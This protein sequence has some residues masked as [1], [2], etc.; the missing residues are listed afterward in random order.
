MMSTSAKDTFQVFVS[1]PYGR[2]EKAKCYWDRFYQYAILDLQRSLAGRGYHINFVRAKEEPSALILKKSV[3]ELIDSSDIC[4]AVITGLNPNVFWEIG[5]A[6]CRE[7]PIIFVVELTVNEPQYSPALVADALKAFYN[8]QI[9]DSDPPDKALVSQFQ[10]ESIVPLLDIAVKHARAA[11]TLVPIYRVLSDRASIELPQTIAGASH[12]IHLLTPDLTYFADVGRFS[13]SI[14][15][16]TQFAFDYPAEQNVMINIL[17]LNPDTEIA[18]YRARQL[19][20][21]CARYRNNSRAAAKFFYQRYRNNRDVDI[22][23]YDD[24]PLQW[25]LVVDERVIAGFLSRS[26]RGRYNIHVELDRNARGVS[27]TFDEHIKGVMA[28]PSA[29]E[30]GKFGWAQTRTR[31]R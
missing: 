12:T 17:A 6:E 15:A 29:V 13:V 7:K 18:E 19:G 5:Y 8:G 31:R 25:T 30:I 4:L 10:R 24:L 3:Q 21:D 28:S 9:Y 11:T 22:R 14:D 27:T 2:D 16:K 26:H 23:L 1:M 20:M